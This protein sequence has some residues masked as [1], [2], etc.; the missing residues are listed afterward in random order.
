MAGPIRA[1][2]SPICCARP[3]SRRPA[4][5]RRC[6]CRRSRAAGS[7]ARPVAWE[8]TGA[9]LSAPFAG[10]HIVE[11]T[12]QV[13][14]AIPARREQRP[15]G[16]GA[17]AGARAVAGRRGAEPLSLA[18]LLAGR[19]ADGRRSPRAMCC[20]PARLV[21]ARTAMAAAATMQ[22]ET[23]GLAAVEAVRLTMALIRARL[24]L[25]LRPPPPV[26]K[27][28]SRSTSPPAVRHP[29]AAAAAAAPAVGARSRSR[30]AIRPAARA[31][32]TAAPRAAGTA[33]RPCRTAAPAPR[34][35]LAAVVLA[36]VE[37]R[38]RAAP[39]PAGSTDWPGGTAPAPTAIRR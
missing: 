4:G 22:R 19:T 35:T 36:V 7:C 38:R 18:A 32:G 1:R 9:T 26:M 25:R 3:G 24:R 11:A 2:R 23:V 33:V 14:R 8:R 27:D 34:R 10:V 29:A 17:R 12:K 6:M 31:A 15:P 20:G 39:A 5:T 21:A 16:A 37:F 28:G 30:P 13:Y